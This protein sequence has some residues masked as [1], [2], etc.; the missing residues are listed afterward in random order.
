MVAYRTDD[1]WGDAKQ[2]LNTAS[3]LW[4]LGSTP[5][6]E[7]ALWH[8]LCSIDW[9]TTVTS[10]DRAPDDLLPLFLPDPRAARITM[11][12]DWMWVRLLDVVRA[13]E[14]RTYEGESELVLEVADH[15]GLTGGRHLLTASREGAPACRA[16]AAPTSRWTWRTWR[17][18]GWAASRRCGSRRWAGCG[19]NER[20]PP[21]RPTPCCVRP[22]DR[23]ARTYSEGGSSRTATVVVRYP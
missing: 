16:R 7:R 2:P 12:A 20:A 11:R 5:A 13:L 9:V 10:G 19:R 21:G 1:R 14:A 4:L 17:R 3:V 6:A 22:G 23:G 18:C 15:A 8:Y